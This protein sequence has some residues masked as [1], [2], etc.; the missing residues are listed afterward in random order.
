M[1]LF[2]WLLSLIFYSF[3]PKFFVVKSN[4]HN[5]IDETDVTVR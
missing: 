5:A 3:Q 1:F 2:I 4:R